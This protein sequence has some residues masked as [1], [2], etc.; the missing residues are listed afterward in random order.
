MIAICVITDK[1]S[2]SKGTQENKCYAVS[3]NDCTQPEITKNI[4]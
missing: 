3:I 1:R 2:E 4:K